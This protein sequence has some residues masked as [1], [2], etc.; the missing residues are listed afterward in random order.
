V[1]RK[2]EDGR[3]HKI[4]VALEGVPVPFIGYLD[5]AGISR[6][7][8]SSVDLKTTAASR[9]RSATRTADRARSTRAPRATMQIRFALRLGEEDRGLC[10]GERGEH[11]AQ[12]V[13]TAKA[14]ENL[15]FPVR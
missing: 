11:I 10:A 14:I 4:E 5:S 7:T 1:P 3:Q 15:P 9:P 13:R 6:S 2:P 12:V 8:G